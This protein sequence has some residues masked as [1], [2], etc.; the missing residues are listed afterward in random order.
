M[1]MAK[2]TT[3]SLPEDLISPLLSGHFEVALLERVGP[4]EHL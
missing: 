3:V 2:P 4:S 1:F